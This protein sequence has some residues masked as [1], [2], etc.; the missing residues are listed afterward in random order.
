MTPRRED[1]ATLITELRSLT[2]LLGQ[3]ELGEDLDLLLRQFQTHCESK[4]SRLRFLRVLS[5]TDLGEEVGK[6]EDVRETM[7]GGHA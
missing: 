7:A 6:E 5:L 3:P 4:N 2:S 1:V